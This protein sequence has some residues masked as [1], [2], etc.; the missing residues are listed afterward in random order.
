MGPPVLER[1]KRSFIGA[2]EGGAMPDPAK[3]PGVGA[4]VVLLQAHG[5]PRTF[6][7]SSGETPLPRTIGPKLPALWIPC[8]GALRPDLLKAGRSPALFP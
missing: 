4:L 5:V 6:T 8:R 2:W 3:E 1:G 7:V